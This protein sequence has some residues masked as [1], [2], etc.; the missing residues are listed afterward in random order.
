MILFIIIFEARGFILEL[1]RY[2]NNL[3]VSQVCDLIEEGTTEPVKCLL[4]DGDYCVL[5]YMR[6][7]FGTMVLI[8]EWIGS[9]LA[10]VL[11]I[12]IPEYGICDLTSDIIEKTNQNDEIDISNKGPAFWSRYYAKTIPLSSNMNIDFSQDDLIRIIVFD[13]ILNNYDRHNGNLLKR[14]DGGK[15]D[16]LFIDNSHI[17]TSY[18]WTI[19]SY[20]EALNDMYMFNIPEQNLDCYKK[21]CKNSGLMKSDIIEGASQIKGIINMDLLDEIISMVPDDWIELINSGIIEVAIEII[22]KRVS[23][24]EEILDLN[25]NREV[26]L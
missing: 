3:R 20:N 22:M 18:P 23:V 16:V 14:M 2:K 21:L 17:L 1:K 4:D 12:S 10:D 13:T 9:C 19:D 11:D 5:K 24:I 6:N 8:N 25:I 15:P 7:N 26:Y